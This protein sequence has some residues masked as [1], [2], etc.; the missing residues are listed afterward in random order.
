MSL[1]DSHAHLDSPRFADDRE[2][3]LR[4]AAEAGV[5]AI[6]TVG[7]LNSEVDP[8]P[9]VLPL[10]DDQPGIFGAVGVHP[11]DA[12]TFDDETAA[13]LLQLLEHPKMVALGEIGL[14][15]YYDH[16]PRETQRTV[17]R[18]QIELAASAKKPIIVHTRDAEDDTA[19]ILEEAFGGSSSDRNGV[20]HCFSSA[21]RLARKGLELGFYVSFGGMLTF[22]KADEIRS[23]ALEVPHNRLLVETDCPYLA[24]VPMRGKRNEPAFVREVA[25]FLGSM[26]GMD[27]DAIGA[28]TTQNFCRLFNL[29]RV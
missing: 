2:A 11:H 3:V 24:P 29:P 20:L 6:L 9:I 23:V 25:E 16:S 22:K 7:C 28:L 10:L 15:Y 14:D 26:L 18:R 19:A 1:V 17:F 27:L 12:A 5:T 21:P 8:L 13:R 4:R